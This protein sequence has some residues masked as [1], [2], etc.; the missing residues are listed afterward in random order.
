MSDVR[1]CS[2]CG[3]P[4]CGDGNEAEPLSDDFCCDNCNDRYVIPTRLEELLAAE[5]EARPPG[6]RWRL[7]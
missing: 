4:Y 2:I 1:A 6:Q 3:E 7:H 5:R